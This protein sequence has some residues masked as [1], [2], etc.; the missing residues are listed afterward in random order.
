MYINT[1]NINTKKKKMAGYPQPHGQLLRAHKK[2]K[3]IN[4]EI[5]QN[6]N[7]SSNNNSLLGQIGSVN[8]C[9]LDR[10]S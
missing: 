7:Y 3:T 5:W 10:S 2:L 8:C 4:I 9:I 1:E 6:N